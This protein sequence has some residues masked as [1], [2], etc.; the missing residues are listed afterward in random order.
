MASE[1]D[2]LLPR[3][4]GAPEINYG[5][6]AEEIETN[7]TEQLKGTEDDE[8]TSSPIRAFFTLFAI[9]V[10]LGILISFFVPGGL[11]FPWDRYPKN[12]TLSTE[13]RVEKILSENPLIGNMFT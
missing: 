5:Y 10:G 6:P 1:Q 13:R 9:V 12:E 8:A 2:P 3:N 11:R 7:D 4:R